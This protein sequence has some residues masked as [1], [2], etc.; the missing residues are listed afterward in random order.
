MLDGGGDV[1]LGDEFVPE[2]AADEGGEVV[3]GGGLAGAVEADDAAGGVEDGDEGVD[4]VEDGGDEVALDGEGGL[5][6]LAGAGDALHH[7]QGAVEFDGGHGLA[8][9][10]GEGLRL[11]RGES[12][13]GCVEY[14]E[15]AEAHSA[16]GDQRGAG[17]EAEGAAG[18]RDCRWEK[19]G[20]WRVSGISKT[21]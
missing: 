14:E 6:A 21:A 13:R 15:R 8:A 18:E 19:P 4:G 16:G 17:I 11:R 10:H 5:D 20:C 3:S 7:A 1:G 9:E 2:I 12:S